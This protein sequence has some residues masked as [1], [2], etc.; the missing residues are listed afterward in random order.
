MLSEAGVG[1][2]ICADLAMFADE[3]EAGAGF[4][5]I[6]EEA[7]A[8]TDVRRLANWIEAQPE[9]FDFPFVLLTRRGG[10]LERNSS[11]LATCACWAT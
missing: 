1:A 11:P 2:R 5:V 10:G 3:L 6:T 8:G 7:L 9:W 4:A